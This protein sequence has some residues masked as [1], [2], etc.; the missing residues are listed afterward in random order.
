MI[1]VSNARPPSW[2]PVIANFTT[3]AASL[4]ANYVP[5]CNSTTHNGTLKKCLDETV[6]P[7][8]QSRPVESE[9]SEEETKEE[10]ED[11]KEGKQHP[12]SWPARSPRIV[13][14][15]ERGG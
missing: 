2:G 10:K 15:R 4:F 14:S 11:E 8:V 6:L 1:N 3:F 13:I 12:K 7:K 9:N 5:S